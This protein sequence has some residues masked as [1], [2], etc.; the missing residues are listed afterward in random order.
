MN[1]QVQKVK[2][3]IDPKI[4]VSGIVTMLAIGGM[5]Y[6]A[7]KAGLGTVAKIAAGGK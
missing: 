2:N 3:N 6:F 4:V 5:V 7:R 1:E